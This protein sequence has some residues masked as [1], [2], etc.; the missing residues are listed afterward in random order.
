[1]LGFWLLEPVLGYQLAQLGAT[2]GFQ[3]TYAFN[4]S[5]VL[6]R[7][8]LVGVESKWGGLIRRSASCQA[9]LAA[10]SRR[11]RRSPVAF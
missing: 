7:L 8:T 6:W 5:S 3:L 11:V 1:M 2:C 4:T 10:S 9:G